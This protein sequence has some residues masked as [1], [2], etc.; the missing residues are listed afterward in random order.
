MIRLGLRLASLGGRWSIVPMILTAVA[1]AFGTSILL[2]ALSFQPALGVRQDHGAWRETRG[3]RSPAAQEPG[4][5]LVSLT[6]DQ[7]EGRPLARVDVAA[8]GEGGPVP[9]GLTRLPAPG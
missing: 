3:P 8:L 4:M 2:F 1:V 9:P 5:T 7:L 6:A